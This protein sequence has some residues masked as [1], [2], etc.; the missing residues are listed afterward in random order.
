MTFVEKG[1]A[2]IRKI[3]TECMALLFILL[4]RRVPWYARIVVLVPLGYI[5]SPLDLIPDGLLFFGQIDD[6]IVVRYSYLL[7]KKIIDP[8]VLAD[9]R[10]RAEIFLSQKGKNR[11]KFAIALSAIWIFLLTFLAIYLI[12]KIHRHGIH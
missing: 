6:L 11:I 7:L 8:L 1:K 4:D 12:K 10:D 2:G 3:L 5:A 9:C